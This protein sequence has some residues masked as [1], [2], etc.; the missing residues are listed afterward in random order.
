MQMLCFPA[1]NPQGEVKIPL[2]KFADSGWCNELN[3]AYSSG[4]YRPASVEEYTA[5]K[6]YAV[7]EIT[8]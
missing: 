7:E 1:E 3:K 5:L 6:G 4:L 2:L 8:A